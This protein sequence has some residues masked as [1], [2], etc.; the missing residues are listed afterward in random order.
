M[1]TAADRVLI[2]TSPAPPTTLSPAEDLVVGLVT[3]LATRTLT[4]PFDVVKILIQVNSKGGSIS[5]TIEEL[6]KA[7]GIAAFWRGN[8]A[9]CLTQ[10]PQTAIKFFVR[11]RLRPVFGKD[12][13]PG[14]RAII[15]AAA[16]IVSQTV[17]Y[18]IDFIHTRILLDPKKYSGIFQSLTTIVKEE[19]VAAFWSGILPT[20]VGAIPFEG[21]QFVCYDGLVDLYKRRT[22]TQAV[23][24]V[25]NSALGAVAGA[26]SQTIAFPFDVV[27][28]RM[29]AGKAGGVSGSMTDAFGQIWAKEGVAGFFRGLTINMIKIVPNT[30]LQYTIYG[31][32]KKAILRYRAAAAKK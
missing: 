16:G 27:R 13:T 2:A 17:V 14:Q 30:A 19:G 8:L 7:D 4:S 23:G 20:I 21:S 11:E 25:V 18:P 5:G 6:W 12:L 22:G 29:I 28:K 32:A 1:L 24:P 3:G 26:I 10:G 9:G 31:E 15:G